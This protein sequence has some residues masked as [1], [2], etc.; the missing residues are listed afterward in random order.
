MPE[1]RFLSSPAEEDSRLVLVVDD[2]PMMRLLARESLEGAGFEVAEAEDGCQAIQVCRER[3]PQVVL[4]DVNMPSMDGFETCSRLRESSF[5]RHTPVLMMT[6]LDDLDSIRRAF[7]VG[8]TDFVNKPINWLILAQRVEYMLRAGRTADDLRLSQ[9]RL[10]D[11]QRIARLGYWELFPGS[12]RLRCST[13]LGRILNRRPEALP[14]T[15]EEYLELVHPESREAV[16]RSIDSMLGGDTAEPLEYR[17]RLADGHDRWV[18]QEAEIR[19]D[20][21]GQVVGV[22]AAPEISAQFTG[23]PSQGSVEPQRPGPINR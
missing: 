12:R 19:R 18:R 9:A 22:A 11:A 1:D 14:R 15:A 21:Q 5:A 23:I 20:D 10:A 4:M 3:Q 6:G 17:L 7:D 2:E 16:A 13:L 8:A